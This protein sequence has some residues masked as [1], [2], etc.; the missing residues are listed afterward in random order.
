M[1]IG[2]GRFVYT[3]RIDLA[4]VK[5]PIWRRIGVDSEMPLAMLHEVIQLAFGWHDVHLHVFEIGPSR[6]ATPDALPM[7]GSGMKWST[8][9]PV[10]CAWENW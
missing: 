10:R 2:N 7:G 4:G 9:T 8:W 6:Y 3:L 5:P 1:P